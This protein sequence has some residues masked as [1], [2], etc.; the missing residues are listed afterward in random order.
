MGLDPKGP[1]GGSVVYKGVMQSGRL[2]G[3]VEF[4]VPVPMMYGIASWTLAKSVSLLHQR[5]PIEHHA[6]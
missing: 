1:N 6:D 3:I 5:W 4:V 2:A